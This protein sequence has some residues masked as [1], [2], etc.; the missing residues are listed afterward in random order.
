M[1]NDEKGFKDDFVAEL[2]KKCE[3]KMKEIVLIDQ[4]NPERVQKLKK[5]P[6]SESKLTNYVESNSFQS[7]PTKK[8]NITTQY[9]KYPKADDLENKKTFNDEVKKRQI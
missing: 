8:F 4:E 6:I 2:Y 5:E 7:S 1:N 9:K 3:P